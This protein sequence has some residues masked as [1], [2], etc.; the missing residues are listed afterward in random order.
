MQNTY[1]IMFNILDDFYRQYKDNESLA[2]LLSDLDP[3]IFTDGMPAD[4]AVYD[5]WVRV[6]EQCFQSDKPSCNEIVLAIV[7]FLKFYQQEFTY[8]FTDIIDYLEKNSKVLDKVKK[9]CC[10]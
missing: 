2:S 10:E 4:P 7:N 3:N 5:D 8:V 1:T 9:L 6:T